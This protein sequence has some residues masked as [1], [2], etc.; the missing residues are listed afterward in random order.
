MDPSTKGVE[1]MQTPT[2]YP[3][4]EGCKVIKSA[5]F[6]GSKLRAAAL[7]HNKNW[8]E[9]L[10]KTWAAVS[11]LEWWRFSRPEDDFRQVIEN[12]LDFGFQLID[13]GDA[14]LGVWVDTM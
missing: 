2:G 4:P 14:K 10:A 8:G 3:R 5:R 6:D 1:Q 9:I 11:G 12:S 7:D 13:S